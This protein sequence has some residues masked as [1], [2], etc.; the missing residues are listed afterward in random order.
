MTLTKRQRR[1]IE[2]LQHLHMAKVSALV[3][4]VHGTVN[5][6]PRQGGGVVKTINS[7]VRRDLVQYAD[8]ASVVL[9]D[10]EKYQA[11]MRRARRRYYVHQRIKAHV[12]YTA[13][14]HTVILPG[15]GIDMYPE[16][17]QRYLVELR[18][19]FGYNLQ[20]ELQTQKHGNQL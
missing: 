12:Q 8:A 10:K 6:T 7:L 1:V 3:C 2:I 20:F 19:T 17:V 11:K 9:F 14:G 18:D 15:D 16:K 4:M 5:P 13:I